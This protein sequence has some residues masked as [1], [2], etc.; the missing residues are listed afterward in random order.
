MKIFNLYLTRVLIS[1]KLFGLEID[2]NSEL[3][4]SEKRVIKMSNKG[5]YFYLN[6]FI[7]N[8]NIIMN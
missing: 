2:F 6:Q 7:C 5:N 1:L 4:K 8:Y 3:R